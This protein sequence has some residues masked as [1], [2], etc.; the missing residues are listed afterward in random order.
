MMIAVA[1]AQPV[2][3]GITPLYG[4]LTG[5]TAV[6]I[7]GSGFLAG[8]TVS[9][10][11]VAATG[12]TVVD[13]T[14]ITAIT[15]AHVKGVVDVSV[16]N[17]AGS[18]TAMSSFAYAA[19]VVL[20]S[21]WVNRTPAVTM[22]HWSDPATSADGQI[23]YLVGK[24]DANHSQVW[25]SVNRGGDWNLMWDSL[26][27]Q[28]HNLSL[29]CSASG[30]KVYVASSHGAIT[31][32]HDGGTSWNETY[33]SS[34]PWEK[35]E[36]SA[37]GTHIAALSTITTTHQ[38]IW[39]SQDSGATWVESGTPIDRWM[40][41]DMSDNGQHMIA[42]TWGVFSS[43]PL[44]GTLW[45]SSDFG[46]TWWHIESA[47][48]AH[49]TNMMVS[50]DGEK[51]TAI[52][53]DYPYKI[54]HSP[55][56]GTTWQMANN[57]TSAPIREIDGTPDGS[58]MA[59]I[60]DQVSSFSTNGGLDWTDQADPEP[61]LQQLTSGMRLAADGKSMVVT[62]TGTTLPGQESRVMRSEAHL[63][64]DITSIT[65]DF[66]EVEGGETITIS[67]SNFTTPAIVS[68]GGILATNVSVVNAETVTC[69]LPP[70]AQGVVDIVL[71]TTAGGDTAANAF[72]YGLPRID[73]V[74][75]ACGPLEGGTVV[76]LKGRYFSG[77]TAVHFDSTPGTN[78]TIIDDT[79]LTVTTP[80]HAKGWV[81]VSVVHAVGNGTSIGAFAYH[82][83]IGSWDWIERGSSPERL[84]TSIASS[85]DG[86]KLA[87]L[88]YGTTS[89]DGHIWISANAGESW[90]F[91]GPAA[92]WLRVASSAN[93]NILVATTGMQDPYNT[94]G[95]GI[96]VSTDSGQN[97]TNRNPATSHK[98]FSV[99]CSADGSK[100]AAIG[101]VAPYTS[102]SVWLSS[103]G[104]ETWTETSL[105]ASSYWKDV[106]ISADGT[107]IVA[108]SN[109]DN[110]GL[111]Y[112]S[113]WTSENFGA[114]WTQRTSAGSRQWSTVTVAEDGLHMAAAHIGTLSDSGG[115]VFTSSDGGL[116]WQLQANSPVGEWVEIASGTSGEKLIGLFGSKSFPYGRSVY[117][118]ADSGAN[119]DYQLDNA[120]FAV[121][122]APYFSSV[123]TSED[124]TRLAA[125]DANAHIW[126]S[127]QV[128]A[129][130]I[131]T[132]SPNQGPIA[133]GTAVIISGSGFLP[134]TRVLIDGRFASDVVVVNETT[135][136][137]ST[138][139]A[140]IAGQVAVAVA[141]RHGCT[142]LAN[143]YTYGT[144]WLQVEHPENS[145]LSAGSILAFGNAN[146]GDLTE[147]TIT[148]RNIG[149]SSL[150]GLSVG[151][152]S[153]TGEYTASQIA[154][155]TLAPAAS[156]TFTLHFQPTETGTRTAQINIL[157]DQNPIFT[158]NLTGNGINTPPVNP[159]E[160]WRQL[161]FPGSTATTGPG[162][163]VATPQ[164][165]GISNLMKFALGM[166]P[167]VPGVL[168]I[169]FETGLEVITYTYT[170]AAAA[171]S[172][173]IQFEVEFSPS[174]TELTWDSTNVNQGDIGSG[175]TP[176]TAIAPKP[177]SGPGFLRLKV[178]AP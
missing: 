129:P 144:S 4:P 61:T 26:P 82:Q 162:A 86:M 36:C 37:D 132:I 46:A 146:L 6:T 29:C 20:G 141:T 98:W 117:T 5:G 92:N 18:D 138:P 175:G 45:K 43:N 108:V 88:S 84:W 165:D 136:T 80:A 53:F 76:T 75:P 79:T 16:T 70:R 95:A 154:S 126:T 94:P 55:D 155:N 23:I 168:P 89:H 54:H 64:P 116:N 125:T 166:D 106:E 31:I 32:S 49:W 163:N 123:A 149:G 11:G 101:Q 83:P 128:A 66:G 50:N 133:G 3:D 7:K 147:K 67:G 114:S 145:T 91:R 148:L 1:F 134:D 174:L 59:A 69:T 161:Y 56:G 48:T 12:V 63:A 122:Q 77:A 173:G 52:S 177:E 34:L 90:Q 33:S 140:T 118:S 135:I 158:L 113:I 10:D 124:G 131:T 15:P 9:F 152:T 85:A 103:N 14:T 60:F 58:L 172:A 104:G 121:Q 27:A 38:K 109:F 8:T 2:V 25:K 68:F 137:A 72:T 78:L 96:Y 41:F 115:K 151:I 105:A 176:V 17:P 153:G 39:L 74:S 35:I 93:G 71:A 167:T 107:K 127:A 51:I 97:W 57:L 13:D 47:G 119:W 142:S 120:T 42:G 24:I 73:G 102:F 28:V 169:T 65:P 160:Q 44:P 112:G 110:N 178:T 150:T 139:P 130:V 159:F 156:T 171:V 19:P 21:S 81:D 30:G 40:R 143:A 164:G 99:S 157:S 22:F 170:P 62:M 111:D 87:A 100:M